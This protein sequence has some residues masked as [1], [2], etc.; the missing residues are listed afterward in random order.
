MTAESTQPEDDQNRRRAI[1]TTDGGWSPAVAFADHLSIAAPALAEVDGTLYCAHRGARQGDKRQLPVRWTSFS[2][3][4][5]QPYVD[6][7]DEANKSL[8]EKVTDGQTEQ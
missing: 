7:L 5:V 8:P 1:Y 4:S 6:A 2:P 3:A